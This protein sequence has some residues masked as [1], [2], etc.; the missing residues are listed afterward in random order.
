MA[1]ERERVNH[2]SYW[3]QTGIVN[4]PARLAGIE[5]GIIMEDVGHQRGFDLGAVSGSAARVRPGTG[6]RRPGR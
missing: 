2:D 6:S 1:E 3:S 5:G 4:V